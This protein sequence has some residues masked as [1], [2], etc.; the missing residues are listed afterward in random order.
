[1]RFRVGGEFAE[2]LKAALVAGLLPVFVLLRSG[3][4]FWRFYV[5]VSN[6]AYKI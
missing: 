3:S 4:W 2:N 5:H 1:M 6:E